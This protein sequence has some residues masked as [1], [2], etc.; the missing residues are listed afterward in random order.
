MSTV[1]NKPKGYFQYVLAVD[2]ETTGLCFNS[3]SPTYNPKT[4]EK[5]QA[6][7]WGIIVADAH[8]LKPIEELYVEIKWNDDSLDACEVDPKFGTY[9]EKI[10]GLSIEHLEEN[11]VT[12][13]DAV[14]QIGELILKYWA[15]GNIRLLGHN[16][17][18]FDLHF[19]REMFRRH[20]IELKF[21]SRHVDTSGCGFICFETYNSDQLFEECGYEARKDHNALDDAKMSL[22]AARTMRLI[23][24]S[25]LDE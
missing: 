15:D 7:S 12:E 5:H 24:Q 19:L 14:L 16:V 17:A 23:F 4:G 18:T 22:G 2:C 6:V 10:H 9:A 21:G 25:A 8:T 3:D 20:G 13:E 11:G 1:N